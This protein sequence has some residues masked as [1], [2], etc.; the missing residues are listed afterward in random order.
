MAHTASIA[1]E[2][3]LDSGMNDLRILVID[4][5]GEEIGNH[6]EWFPRTT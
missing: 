5:D 2:L 3:A 4:A 6:A 1:K